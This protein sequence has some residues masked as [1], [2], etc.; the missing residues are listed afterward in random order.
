MSQSRPL[1]GK[2]VGAAGDGLPKGS[3]GALRAGSARFDAFGL[4]GLGPPRPASRSGSP[5]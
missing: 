4:P 3:A 2:L 5:S 1:D